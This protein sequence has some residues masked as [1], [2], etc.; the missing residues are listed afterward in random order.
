MGGATMTK[1]Q[2]GVKC[3]AM[4]AAGKS[5]SCGDL[6]M[7]F[8]WFVGGIKAR[9]LEEKYSV[10]YEKDADSAWGRVCFEE[11]FR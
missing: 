1:F 10:R 3:Y 2:L 6:H 5:R 11:I 9:L 4:P 8:E 7:S